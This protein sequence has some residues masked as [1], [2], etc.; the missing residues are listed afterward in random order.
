VNRV[1]YQHPLAYLLGLEG[2][3]LLHSFAGEYDRE[4]AHARLREIRELVESPDAFGAGAE[5]RPISIRD[6]YDRWAPWYDEQPN[7]LLEIEQ[8]I[9]REIL[10]GLPVGGA[11]DAACGTGRHAAYLASLGHT[12]IGVDR[13]PG[14]LARA[15]E[16]VP[17]GEFYEADFHELP[18]NDDSVDLVVCAIA[19]VHVANIDGPFR[20]F[21]RVLRPGGHLVVSDMCGLL[22][23]IIFPVVR[24]GP[25]GEIG[26]IPAYGHRTSDYLAAAL[27][28]GFQL[29][30]CEETRVPSPLLDDEG[31]TIHDDERLPQQDPN[32]PPNVWALHAEAIDATNAA[33]RAKPSSIIFDFRLQD[34][35]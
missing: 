35:Q 2:I 6:G 9:V 26:Y 16:K 7:Q 5:A 13:S 29:I 31:R 11:L 8:P 24:A 19:L 20:E 28:L 22:G 10:D 1:I 25:A 33:W 34:V 15:R 17:Q 32:Q 4:F 23:G 14:M 30:K 21:A 3:A 12:I 18:V 27:P